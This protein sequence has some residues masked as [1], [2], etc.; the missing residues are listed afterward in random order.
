MDGRVEQSMG[1]DHG[2]HAEPGEN[3]REAGGLIAEANPQPL[4]RSQGTRSSGGAV[5]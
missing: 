5:S 1:T 4:K 2:G 3:V